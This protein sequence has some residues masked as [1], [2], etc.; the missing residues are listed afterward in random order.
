MGIVI[1]C[2]QC[3]A[4]RV[5]KTLDEVHLSPAGVLCEEC[6]QRHRSRYECPHCGGMLM[7]SQEH[8]WICHRCQY[9]CLLTEEDRAWLN[10]KKEEETPPWGWWDEVI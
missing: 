6:Y 10:A 3:E 8:L 7:I 2:D 1:V 4:L 5:C 9:Q